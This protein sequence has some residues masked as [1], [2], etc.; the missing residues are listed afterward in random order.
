MRGI[1]DP[2]GDVGEQVREDHEH[3]GDEQH[4]HQDRVVELARRVDGQ[5]A[6]ARATR[7]SSR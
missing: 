6:D 2:V 3:G 5:L 7:R 4:A 1:D